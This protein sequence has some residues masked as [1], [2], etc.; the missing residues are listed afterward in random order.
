MGYGKGSIMLDGKA[1]GLKVSMEKKPVEEVLDGAHKQLIN[2][3][4]SGSR[5]A[6]SMQQGAV[7]FVGQFNN[8]ASF[9]LGL[10]KNAGTSYI[11]EETGD[12]GDIKLVDKPDTA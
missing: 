3:M 7:D 1:M 5:L 6:I 9:P 10:F 4:K 12:D 2:A 8:D 11:T